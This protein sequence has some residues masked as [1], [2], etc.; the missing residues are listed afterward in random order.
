MVPWR[1]CGA[2]TR[3]NGRVPGLRH[4]VS[5]RVITLVYQNP[6]PYGRGSE[7]SLARN[8]SWLGT[9]PRRVSKR[10]ANHGK[11]RGLGTSLLG[12]ADYCGVAG[13]GEGELGLAVG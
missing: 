9:E 11:S 5:D 3:A 10:C 2:R 8:R 4:Q 7:P 12:G 13:G 1:D 6:L